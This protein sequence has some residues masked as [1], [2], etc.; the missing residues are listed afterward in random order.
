MNSP[1]RYNRQSFYLDQSSKQTLL[2]ALASARLNLQQASEA[3]GIL[4]KGSTV[5]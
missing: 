1:Y 5:A 4:A 3:Q 2:E